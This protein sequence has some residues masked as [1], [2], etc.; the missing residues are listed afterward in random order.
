[1]RSAWPGV[2]APHAAVPAS[3]RR[4]RYH[5]AEARQDAREVTAQALDYASWVSGP[6]GERIVEIADEYVGKAGA[7]DEAFRRRFGTELPDVLNAGH[8]VLVVGSQIDA[9]T[10]RIIRYLAAIHG[11]GINA[12]TFQHFRSDTGAELLSRLVMMEQASDGGKAYTKLPPNL[13]F[14]ELRDIAVTDGIG[15]WWASCSPTSRSAKPMRSSLPASRAS[16]LTICT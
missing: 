13:T 9:S 15:A 1:M 14:E 7:V 8:S 11:V 12:V 4:L 10:E 2:N 16:I 3:A 6:S 5:R